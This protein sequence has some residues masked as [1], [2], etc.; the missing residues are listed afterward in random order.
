MLSPGVTTREFLSIAMW[1]LL[2]DE[3]LRTTYLAARE[4][5][6]LSILE[7]ILR[8]E[9]IVGTIYRRTSEPLELGE[10]TLPAGTKV[11][12]D[13]RA[14]NC[15]EAAAG[16]YSPQ[17]ELGS[18]PSGRAGSPILSFGE[19]HHRCPGTQLATLESNVRKTQLIALPAI[20]MAQV[21]K[22]RSNACLLGTSRAT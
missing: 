18:E 8:L 11:E 10:N 6:G 1:H 15:D 17:I 14:I 21:P 19:G 3:S 7:D 22:V 13:V 20:R 16:E 4:S 2:R 5:K 9:P 12:I